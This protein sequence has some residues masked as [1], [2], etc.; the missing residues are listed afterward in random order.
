MSRLTRCLGE[1]FLGTET[2]RYYK[3]ERSFIREVYRDNDKMNRRLRVSK[4]RQALELTLTRYLP[5]VMDAVAIAYVA[6]SRNPYA[7]ILLGESEFL[8]IYGISLSKITQ[9]KDKKRFK[10]V[11]NSLRKSQG[12]EEMV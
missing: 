3:N 6:I 11:I 2:A 5:N 4:I 7:L 8:R 1:Y 9:Y 10:K 12:L